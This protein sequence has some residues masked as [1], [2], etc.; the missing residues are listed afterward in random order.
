MTGSWLCLTFQI[1][2]SSSDH[3]HTKN[4]SLHIYEKTKSFN[5]VLFNNFSDSSPIWTLRRN[6]RSVTLAKATTVQLDPF[7]TIQSGLQWRGERY[8]DQGTYRRT[9]LWS[10]QGC[11]T[12]NWASGLFCARKTGRSLSTSGHP[13]PK[14][15]TVQKTHWQCTGGVSTGLVYFVGHV[16][17]LPS[18]K[19]NSFSRR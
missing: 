9:N 13:I 12:Q 10:Y 5:T 14:N 6:K 16:K 17:G 11:R 18:T 4:C 3:F 15:H 2:W 19:S 1:A 7:L 8:R